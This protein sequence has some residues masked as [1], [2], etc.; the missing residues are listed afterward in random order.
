MTNKTSSSLAV[1]IAKQLTAKRLQRTWTRDELANRAGINVYTL[2]H[3]ERT[4]QISLERL[5]AVCRQL[6]LLSDLER[7]FKPRQR[8]DV[9][10][11]E[12][13]E[14]ETMRKRGK[15]RAREKQDE[16]VAEPA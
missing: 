11:W 14:Q 7:V 10:N 3:F 5:I 2:K 13:P 16:V 12:A 15:R 1:E 6:D 9:D 8:I 4:G